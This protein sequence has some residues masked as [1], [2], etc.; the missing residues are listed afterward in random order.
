MGTVMSKQL[1]YVFN[2]ILKDTKYNNNTSYTETSP[3][4]SII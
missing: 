2:D 1:H 3:T 4:V